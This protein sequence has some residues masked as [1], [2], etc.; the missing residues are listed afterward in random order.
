VS[1]HYLHLK[2]GD[3]PPPVADIAPFKAVIIIEDDVTIQWRDRVSD[4]L[5]QSGCLYMMAWGRDCS[6]WDDSVDWASLEMHNYEEIPDENLVITTW[7]DQD[8][9][10]DVFLFSAHT[11]QHP[12]KDL[13]NTLIVDIGPNAREASILSLYETAQRG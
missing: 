13:G 9:L 7:H 3:D 11:A 12:V 8:T 10:E 1:P 4:W 5:V 6:I 2:P